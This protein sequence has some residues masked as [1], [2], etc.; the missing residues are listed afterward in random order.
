MWRVDNMA[1]RY[2]AIRLR[3]EDGGLD[4]SLLAMNRRQ[5]D[6]DADARQVGRH[7]A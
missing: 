6:G 3:R 2:L 4:W 1:V 7:D 5:H